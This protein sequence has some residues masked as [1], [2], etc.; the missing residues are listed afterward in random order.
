MQYGPRPLTGDENMIEKKIEEIMKDQSL[1]FHEAYLS[2][3][4]IGQIK[5]SMTQYFDYT[6]DYNIS[7]F[8]GRGFIDGHKRAALMKPNVIRT[9]KTLLNVKNDEIILKKLE[10]VQL[11]TP[12][13]LLQSITSSFLNI[14]NHNRHAMSN[15]NKIEMLE[16]IIKT[17][18]MIMVDMQ[19]GPGLANVHYVVDNLICTIA[20]PF[21]GITNHKI[22][23]NTNSTV[24]KKCIAEKYKQQRVIL[25]NT[26]KHGGGVKH[27]SHKIIL[28]SLCPCPYFNLYVNDEEQIKCPHTGKGDMHAQ[29]LHICYY[30]KSDTHPM[31]RCPQ[32]RS[33]WKPA[34]SKDG[35]L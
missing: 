27:G 28:P 13:A 23:T 31:S 5:Q 12:I 22:D 15:S 35:G 9:L 21:Y 16:E 20:D 25:Q 32:F 1:T 4:T 11:H 18:E 29:L 2:L 7:T 14:Y 17:N 24:I 34:F 3:Y 33:V 30:C 19:Q 6:R 8:L 26:L 10:D